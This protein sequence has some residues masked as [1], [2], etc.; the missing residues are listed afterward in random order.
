MKIVRG[1]LQDYDIA[2][3]T[4]GEKGVHSTEALVQTLNADA[5]LHKC[6]F[7]CDD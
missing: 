5:G 3:Q 4:F 6:F 7:F 2:R 1:R